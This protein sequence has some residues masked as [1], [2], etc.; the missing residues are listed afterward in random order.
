MFHIKQQVTIRARYTM[1]ESAT[2][3]VV[4]NVL[5]QRGKV[6]DYFFSIM[7]ISE[8]LVAEMHSFTTSASQK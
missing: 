4:I 2:F 3:F 6:K 8:V 5:P 7:N 1:H